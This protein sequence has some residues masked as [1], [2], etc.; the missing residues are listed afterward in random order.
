MQGDKLVETLFGLVVF[1]QLYLSNRLVVQES[2][3]FGSIAKPLGIVIDGP[4]IIT[5]I[6][7]GDTPHLVSVHDKGVAL[8]TERAIL[9]GT[10]VVVEAELGDT[11][12]EIG[13]GHIGFHLDYLIEIL[14]RQDV[15]L[16]VESVAPDIHHPV[17]VDLSHR[18]E[19]RERE[20]Q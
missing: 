1:F 17:G 20:Q 14:H 6:L 5:Q 18:P 4:L 10:L 3:I 8:D 11:P 7:P 13:L 2:T 19:R 15:I 9:L 16:E 12:V